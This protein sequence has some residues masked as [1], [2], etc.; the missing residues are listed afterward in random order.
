MKY[1]PQRS[2]M[3]NLI[4]EINQDIVDEYNHKRVK[5]RIEYPIHQL[6]KCY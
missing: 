2:Y 4:L 5:K 3:V 1:D 6:Y